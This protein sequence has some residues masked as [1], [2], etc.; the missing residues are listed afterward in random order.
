MFQMCSTTVQYGHSFLFCYLEDTFGVNLFQT[1][2][3]SYK[4]SS[5]INLLQKC[6]LNNNKKNYNLEG[7]P[8]PTLQT[9]INMYA[10][11]T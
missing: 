2:F 4:M 8:Q 9:D 1:T 11:F 3:R 10:Y 6:L 5:E 7:K